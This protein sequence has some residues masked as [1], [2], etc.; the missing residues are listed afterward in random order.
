MKNSIRKSINQ[1]YSVINISD[2]E[3][4][5]I[6]GM[7]EE[8]KITPQRLIVNLQIKF[9][10]SDAAKSD[11]IDDTIDYFELTKIV[12]DF[13]ENSRFELLEKLADQTLKIINQFSDKIIDST[14]E[15]KKPEAL[16]E[17]GAMVSFQKTFRI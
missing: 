5:T 1:K 13:I 12:K 10:A 11:N 8:E 3:V 15:I 9:D 7:L 14:I 2:L 6:I 17:F 16:K 4:V